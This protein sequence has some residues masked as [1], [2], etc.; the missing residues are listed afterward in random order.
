[1]NDV[2]ATRIIRWIVSVPL[3]LVTALGAVL[4]AW[5]KPGE[6]GVLWLLSLPVGLGFVYLTHRLTA[7]PRKP[8]NIGMPI[9][10]VA[11]LGA[12]NLGGAALGSMVLPADAPSDLALAM[13][14]MTFF[15]SGLA[16]PAL[17]IIG[18]LK[19]VDRIMRRS[20]EEAAVGR[21]LSGQ[22][23]M[24]VPAGTDRFG[25][26]APA[27]ATA[28]SSEPSPPSG[29]AH[30][31]VP[32]P[33]PAPTPGRPAMTEV[34]FLELSTLVEVAT[35]LEE[36]TNPTMMLLTFTADGVEVTAAETELG[37]VEGR[38]SG[39]GTM[40][41][42]QSS[43]ALQEALSALSPAPSTLTLQPPED[44]H[45]DLEITADSGQRITAEAIRA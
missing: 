1:M 33:A 3:T 32:S 45:G 36:T 30:A 5:P 23:S 17:L 16:L 6:G 15:W 12:L 18:V 27:P 9:A 34:P 13:M 41:T 7:P 20:Q 31:P 35:S 29:P 10:L 40:R 2:S 42:L 37:T 43:R 24:P 22:T 14:A 39:H 19:L 38:W 28:E 44:D 25:E 8:R 11:G 21:A 4:W 26:R